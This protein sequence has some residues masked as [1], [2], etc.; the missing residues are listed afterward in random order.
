MR[1]P[2]APLSRSA[3]KFGDG[4]SA[5]AGI[6]RIVAGHRL[7]QQRAILTVQAIGPVWSS[8]CDSGNTP[9][10][11]DKSV[12]RL[13]PG[14]AAKRGGPRIEPPVSEPVPPSTIPAATAAPVP[15]DDPA[16]K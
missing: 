15:D 4:R 1:R 9:A 12:G 13:D 10:R 14:E 5:L 2:L 3:V 6:E 11:L 16:V 7:Q 8:V